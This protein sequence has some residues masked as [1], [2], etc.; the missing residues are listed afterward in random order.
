[1]QRWQPGEIF[2][3]LVAC[4]LIAL[5]FF[6]LDVVPFVVD[7]P[8]TLI[9]VDEFFSSGEFRWTLAR[10]SQ[11]HFPYGAGALWFYI[12]PKLISWNPMASVWF[13]TLFYSAG[14][15]F[16]YEG[17]RLNWGRLPALL[18]LVFAASS[19]F[20][21]FGSRHPWDNTLFIPISGAVLWLI[22]LLDRERREWGT[23]AGLVLAGLAAVLAW[24]VN[25]HLMSLPL[26]AAAGVA[27][28]VHLLRSEW[29]WRDRWKGGALCLGLLV[30]LVTPYAIAAVVRFLHE[31][32]ESNVKRNA[33]WGDG[34]NLWWVTLRSTLYG[35]VYGAKGY[36][37]PHL[38]AFYDATG[39]ISFFFRKDIFGWIP[40]CSAYFFAT[41]PV[42]GW[43]RWR[44][45]KLAEI[46]GS[47]LLFLFL[48]NQ[49]WANI[50]T[51]PH[52]YVVV[53]WVVFVGAAV[54]AFSAGPRIRM[55]LLAF[56]TGT[57]LINT[58]WNLSFLSWVGEKRGTR[59]FSLYLGAGDQVKLVGDICSRLRGRGLDV[60]QVDI[61]EARGLMHGMR[62][63]FPNHPEC[64]GMRVAPTDSGPGHLKI[65]PVRDDPHSARM[66]IQP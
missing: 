19:P 46:F 15:F 41:L 65:V 43:K 51:D 2:L 53:W 17:V 63:L 62:Y 64:A 1:M 22:S 40:K 38:S 28:A 30:A 49:Q 32:F 29:S 47:A 44:E 66:E 54:T 39:P 35:S 7:E 52:H 8:A 12:L 16:L 18:A 61:R 11:I 45:L 27:V 21:F 9:R 58:A 56:M 13:H 20:L 57:I 31:P 34:R 14:F 42:F 6:H 10:G 50:P 55:M 48:L 23:R 59:S 4:C 33:P 24:G 26:V 3:G 37:D 25:I 5:R 60:A 36:L